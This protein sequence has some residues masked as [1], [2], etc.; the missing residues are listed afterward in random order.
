MKK[1]L[2]A[3]RKHPREFEDFK[4][5]YP[6]LSRRS[7]GISIGLN[8]NPDRKCSFDCIYCQVDRSAAPAT[9]RFDL[10][11]AEKE[12][13][14]MLE[15]VASGG[16][17]KHPQFRGVPAEQ[18][19]LKDVALSGDG[20][21]TTLLNFAETVEMVAH[22]KPR[23]VKLLLITDAAGLDRSNVKRGLATMDAHNGE[24][25]AKLD[26]GTED[27][28]K[29]IDRSAIPFARILKN[30]TECAQARPIVIQSL[31]MKL[32]GH[33][34]SAEEIVAY[35]ERLQGILAAG[36]RIKQ[37]QISTVAR[38]PMAMINGRPSWHSV[39]ALGDVELDAIRVCVQHRTGL[40][41]E[42]YYGGHGSENSC[43]H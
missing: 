22:L 24:V 35:C 14:A 41:C 6:V 37:V 18:L 1:L 27:Y 9:E 8:V 32:Y 5:V 26:A 25:W 40:A 39:T 20:E 11:V 28:F 38:R 10:S 16:L 2:A 15:W 3:H 12:M 31:F 13:A 4:F 43:G 34:P 42:S 30:L 33:G 17:V 21:P 36:G 19:Q 29:L 7:G 23:E